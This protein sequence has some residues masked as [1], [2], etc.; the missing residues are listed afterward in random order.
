MRALKEVAST[1]RAEIHMPEQISAEVA[2]AATLRNVISLSGLTL[3]GTFGTETEPGALLRTSGGRIHRV[4]PGDSVGGRRIA[5]I[6][7][8]EVV[9]ESGGRSERLEM[10]GENAGGRPAMRAGT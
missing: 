9:L 8:G 10:P 4:T 3:I 5:A 1:V 6:G 7:V 2:Q